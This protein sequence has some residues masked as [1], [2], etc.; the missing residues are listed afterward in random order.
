M[1]PSTRLF[2][3]RHGPTDAP[4]G[5]LLGSTDV[6]LSGKGLSQLNGLIGTH[7]QTVERWHC[8]PLLR[9][10][11]TLDCLRQH[12]CPVEQPVYDSR[13]REIHF[14]DWELRSFA[15]IAA[16][17]PARIEAWQQY[18]DFVFPGGEAVADFVSRIKG[19]LTDIAESGGSIGVVTH[20]GVIRTMICLALGLPPRNYLLFDVQPASL[21]VLDIFSGGGV[22]RGLN[23]CNG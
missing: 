10:R 17:D 1:S 20:G 2:L 8:S 15:D 5:S 11:Q 19:V 13:L 9:A 6:P 18:E 12:G 4:P 3:L 14:G 22:L 21:T 23:L 7:L 16:A